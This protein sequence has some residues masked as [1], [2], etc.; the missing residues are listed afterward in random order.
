MVLLD[1]VEGIAVIT[2]SNIVLPLG[3]SIL[4][5][6]QTNLIPVT[7]SW[8][9]RFDGD[10]VQNLSYFVKPTVNTTY[11][12]LVTDAAGC[13]ATDEVTIRVD[14]QV[15]VFA[16]NAFSPNGDG[17]NDAFGIY[18]NNGV[19]F[20]RDFMIFN[21]WGESVHVT[22]GELP[23]N[24]TAWHWDGKHRGEVM[25]P[26]VFIYQITAVLAD[27]REELVRGEVILLK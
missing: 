26:A 8:S 5:V 19:S 15:P 18:G 9:P 2:P 12:L 14:R 21:R 16:P 10:T 22:D 24:S 17:V 11:R 27:G 1:A 25:N 3:D 6:G 23:I 7:I 4:L 20:F 13:T